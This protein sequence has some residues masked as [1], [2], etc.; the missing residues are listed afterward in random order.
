MKLKTF[1]ALT[2]S[3]LDNGTTTFAQTMIYQPTAAMRRLRRIVGGNLFDPF[4]STRT[5]IVPSTRTVSYIFKGASSTA[6]HAHINALMVDD[7]GKKGTLT[8]DGQDGETYS[9]TAALTGVSWRP[10]FDVSHENTAV[11]TLT[12]EEVTLLEQD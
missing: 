6:L 3:N 1:T 8:F 5:K 4:G 10:L 2:V 12:V 9:Q 7:V 11:V